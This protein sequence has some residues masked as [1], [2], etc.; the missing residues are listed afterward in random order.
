M[1]EPIITPAALEQD[2]I[3]HSIATAC[4]QTMREITYG[5]T[6]ERLVRLAARQVAD[7]GELTPERVAAHLHTTLRALSATVDELRQGEH[8]DCAPNQENTSAEPR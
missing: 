4:V 6:P 8:A 7:A 5:V 2:G 3:I 1:S